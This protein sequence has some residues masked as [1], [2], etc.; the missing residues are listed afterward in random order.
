MSILVRDGREILDEMSQLKRLKKGTDDIKF[1]MNKYVRIHLL[2]I[3]LTVSV[4]IEILSIN[5]TTSSFA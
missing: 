2:G 1:Y 5:I 4:K 3:L